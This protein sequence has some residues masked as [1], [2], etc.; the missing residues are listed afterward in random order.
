MT[1]ELQLYRALVDLSADDEPDRVLSHLLHL[2][3]DATEARLGYV[4]IGRDP[5]DPDWW[6]ATSD[7]DA[8]VA[9]LRA[10]VSRTI[11]GAVA[12]GGLIVTSNAATDPRFADRASVQRHR[13]EQVLCAP[14]PHGVLYLQGRR[15]GPLFDDDDVALARLLVR[16]LGPLTTTLYRRGRWQADPTR[17]IRRRLRAE[18]LVG[19]SRAMAAV[20]QSIEEVAGLEVGVLFTGSSGTGKSVAARVLHDNSP[21]CRGPLVVVNCA[22]LRPDRL[23]ADLFGTAPGSY[24]GQKGSR[25]G[26]VGAASSGTLFLDEVAELPPEAQAQLL[27]FLQDHRYRRLGEERERHAD[28]RVV[29]AT[30][31]DLTDPARFRPDL[32]WRLATVVVRMPSLSERLD[33]L[34][35]LCTALIAELA[36]QLGCPALPVHPDALAVLESRPWEGNLRQLRQ[37]LLRGVL[38]ARR[39][40]AS[41]ID[42]EALS[43][44]DD[45]RI[46]EGPPTDRDLRRAVDAFK[47]R[48]VQRVLEECDGNR[49]A[50]AKALGMS[51]S[52]LHELLSRWSGPETNRP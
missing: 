49:S 22:S 27:L 18:A 48:H 30:S 26:L 43:A 10:R 38:A 29:A 14:L 13:I 12:D 7:D 32:Y 15:D 40:G 34:P 28:V 45:V 24:T 39:R 52:Y 2:V 50:A 8:P 51:R 5:T 37:V 33:D 19:R 17:P 16:H 11:V 1:R 6:H 25:E 35:E 21:R 20:L 23:H 9:D 46:V 4:A 36:T 44:G 47:R 42:A 41:S 3:V 31:V